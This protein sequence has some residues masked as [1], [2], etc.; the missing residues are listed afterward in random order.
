[1]SPPRPSGS[2]GSRP[3]AFCYHPKHIGHSGPP[4]RPLRPRIVRRPVGDQPYGPEVRPKGIGNAELIH[5]I[6]DGMVLD[7][8]ARIAFIQRARETADERLATFTQV[9]TRDS[10]G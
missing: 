6:A 1:M 9:A 7:H 5:S 8:V 3:T 2:P 10:P 4:D